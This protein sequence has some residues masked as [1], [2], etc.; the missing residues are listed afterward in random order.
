MI[1]SGDEKANRCARLPAAP[2][3]MTSAKPRRRH[4]CGMRRKGT[5]GGMPPCLRDIGDA[6]L[7]DAGRD[8]SK[9]RESS[10]KWPLDVALMPC[11]P[12]RREEAI[13]C[14]EPRR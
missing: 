3:C 12:L 5:A 11:S 1:A 4:L 7:R 2:L 8:T 9:R 13:K 14:R 6:I 10:T